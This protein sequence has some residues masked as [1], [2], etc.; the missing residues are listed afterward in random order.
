MLGCCGGSI[1]P[2][3]IVQVVLTAKHNFL[4]FSNSPS[5]CNTFFKQRRV[6]IYDLVTS[7]GPWYQIGVTSVNPLHFGAGAESFVVEEERIYPGWAPGSPAITWESDVPYEAG[8]FVQE[9]RFRPMGAADW[10]YRVVVTHFDPYTM[11]DG[12]EDFM[13]LFTA[14]DVL[15]PGINLCQLQFGMG[16]QMS[17]RL[18]VMR[19]DGWTSG[20]NDNFLGGVSCRDGPLRPND[21][22]AQTRGGRAGFT[23][24]GLSLTAASTTLFRFDDMGYRGGGTFHGRKMRVRMDRQA[25]IWKYT[26]PTPCGGVGGG[27]QPGVPL[28]AEP[29]CQFVALPSQDNP[30]PGCPATWPRW[31]EFALMPDGVDAETEEG[32]PVEGV[33]YTLAGCTGCFTRA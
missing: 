30:D 5:E 16:W 1:V 11:A 26:A 33:W 29:S 10:S 13:A 15:D 28:C 17:Y 9:R 25:C 8:A 14:H 4:L 7:G 12:M 19:D 23:K 6:E 31:I 3:R 32:E 27:I 18:G 24:Y 20:I 2:A 21:Q 22:S